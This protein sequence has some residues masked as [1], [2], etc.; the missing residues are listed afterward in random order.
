M[1][2]TYEELLDG[3]TDMVN[4]FAYC[5]D[6]GNGNATDTLHTGGLSALENAFS[7]LGL[8]E[9][10]TRQELWDLML[11]EPIPGFGQ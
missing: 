11:G 6:S 2:A 4:Q 9:N 5:D 1:K 10:C 8:E 3:L 7:I